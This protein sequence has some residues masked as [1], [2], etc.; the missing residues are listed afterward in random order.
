M[1]PCSMMC[2]ANCV[3]AQCDKLMMIVGQTKLTKL[4]TVDES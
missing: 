3:A 1:N 4:V 2:D